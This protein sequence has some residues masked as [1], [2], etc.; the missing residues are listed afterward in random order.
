MSAL[1]LYAK[2]ARQTKGTQHLHALEAL[3]SY[4]RLTTVEEMIRHINTITDTDTLR[5]IQE[6]GARG[7]L[8]KAL[9]SRMNLLMKE[10]QEAK[11]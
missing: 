2:Q 8:Y 3:R 5:T 6:A 1:E 10:Q 4:M 7:D 11:K 9:I